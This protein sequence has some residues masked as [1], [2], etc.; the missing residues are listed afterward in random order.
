MGRY[1]RNIKTLSVEE[2]ERLKDFRV[3]VIGC[4]GIGGYVIEMLG[5]L[6]I[7]HITAVDG[8]NFCE[9]NL[10]RQILSSNKTMGKNKAETA[11]D[12][13]KDVND[14]IEV[15]AVPEFINKDNILD[16]I[17]GH[18]VVIDALD[19]IETRLLLQDACEKAGIPLVHGAIGGWYGQV[20][21][22]F[23]GD[24]TLDVIY[25]DKDQKG[26]EKTL[27]NPSFTPALIASIQVS[28]AV[29]ILINKKDTLRNKML[30]VDL[31]S[32]DFEVINL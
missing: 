31:L 3:C 9:S 10:N 8:D 16:I 21:S 32:Q 26:I 29:K 28:E 25:E 4:G 1:E 24:R 30:V 17:E 12:R 14:L 20:T 6:G 5:R 19:N 7:G 23:P 13:M 11:R 15:T 2:N 27:G 22:I 18:H